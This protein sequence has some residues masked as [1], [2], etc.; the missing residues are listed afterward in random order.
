MRFRMVILAAGSALLLIACSG[1]D[2]SPKAAPG[3][4]NGLLDNRTV[5][6]TDNGVDCGAYAR[7]QGEGLPETAAACLM[8]ALKAGKSVRLR[9]SYPTVEGDP[10]LVTYR[11]TGGGE[12]EVSTDST[13]DRW[14]SGT[15]VQRRTCTGPVLDEGFL[16]FEKCL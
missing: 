8:T 10:I 4:N 2:E 5:V 16:R 11:S 6:T 13:H 1:S 9:E 14:D 3:N 7:A 12:V 15:V